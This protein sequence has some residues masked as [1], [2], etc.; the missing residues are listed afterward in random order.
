[1][2]A[3]IFFIAIHCLTPHLLPQGYHIC[4]LG[5]NRTCCH[6]TLWRQP[7]WTTGTNFFHTKHQICIDGKTIFEVEITEGLF[8][9]LS[10]SYCNSMWIYGDAYMWMATCLTVVAYSCFSLDAVNAFLV[11]CC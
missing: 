3:K 9:I 11:F 7:P 6:L 5:N 2:E 8:I 10:D 1:M 4:G